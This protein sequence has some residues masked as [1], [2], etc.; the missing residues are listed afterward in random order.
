MYE[1]EAERAAADVRHGIQ[2]H[3]AAMECGRIAAHLGHQRVRAFVA[4]CGEQEDDVPDRAG[5]NELRIHRWRL[6]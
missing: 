6:A 3:L 1:H 4:C 5:N 2:R